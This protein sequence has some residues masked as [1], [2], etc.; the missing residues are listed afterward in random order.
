MTQKKTTEFAK[1][2]PLKSPRTYISVIWFKPVTIC[3]RYCEQ[4]GTNSWGIIHLSR[5]VVGVEYRCMDIPDHVNRDRGCSRFGVSG[6]VLSLY[7]QAERVRDAISGQRLA[8]IDSAGW[9]TDHKLSK[10]VGWGVAGLDDLVSDSSAVGKCWVGICGGDGD[11]QVLYTDVFG[12]GQVVQTLQEDWGIGVTAN[13][14][15]HLDCSKS[16]G[17][18]LSWHISGLYSHLKKKRS[19][20]VTNA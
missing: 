5:V 6:R 7:N 8:E 11:H 3:G 12:D 13:I 15:S 1:F 17:S 4:G 16:G 14:Y 9:F 10:L 2:L 20:N 18:Y 19:Q